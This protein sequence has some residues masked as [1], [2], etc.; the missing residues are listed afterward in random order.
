MQQQ[1]DERLRSS[2]K[3]IRKLGAGKLGAGGTSDQ[4]DQQQL[5]AFGVEKAEASSRELAEQ[6]SKAQDL[7]KAVALQQTHPHPGGAG[8]RWAE[9]EIRGRIEKRRGKP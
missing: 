2:S 6:R 1:L 9:R 8:N 3:R 7:A 4:Q 5:V